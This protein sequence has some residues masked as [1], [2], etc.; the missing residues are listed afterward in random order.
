MV[1]VDPSLPE[2]AQALLAHEVTPQQLAVQRPQSQ[3]RRRQ[4]RKQRNY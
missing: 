1:F 4:G 2:Q 3:L